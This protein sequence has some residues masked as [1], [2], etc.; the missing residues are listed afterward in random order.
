MMQPPVPDRRSRSVGRDSLANEAGIDTDDEM[1]L[2]LLAPVV[3]GAL[4]AAFPMLAA[5]ATGWLVAHQVLVSPASSP[6]WA[7]PGA[8][9]AGLDARR[10]TALVAVL[11]IAVGLSVSGLWHRRARRREYRLRNGDRR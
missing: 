5:R 7:L 4:A 9:G 6:V 2:I 3:L 8:D 1:S 11:V 10:L